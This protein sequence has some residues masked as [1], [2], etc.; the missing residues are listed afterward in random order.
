M[1]AHAMRTLGSV[2]VAAAL[3]LAPVRARAQSSDDGWSAFL[4]ALAAAGQ[5]VRYNTPEGDGPERAEGY[6]HV[7]RLVEFAEASF[8]DDADAAHPNVQ[9]CPS[10]ACKIGF[11]NPDQVYVGIGPISDAYTYRVFGQRGTVDFLSF[12]VFDNPY[13]GPAW[14]DSDALQVKADGSWE[15]VLSP[16]PRSGNWLPTTASSTQLV[17][18]MTFA[19]WDSE[20]EGSVQVEV[21]DDAARIPVPALVP[22]DFAARAR[23]L[24]TTLRA[25]PALFQQLRADLYPVNDFADPDPEAFGL[26]NAGLPTNVVSPAQYDLA[27][28]EALIVESA[29]VPVRFRNIQ[30]GN[31]W[32]E[33]LDY[34]TRQTSLNGAQSYLDRDGVYRFVLAHRDPGV[35][36]WLDVGG[37]PTGTIFMRWNRP[38]GLDAPKPTATVVKLAD[39]RAHLPADHPRVTADERAAMLERRRQAYDR[40]TNPAGLELGADRRVGSVPRL[41]VVRGAR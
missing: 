21:L 6:R 1:H 2:V 9:R 31:R 29:D 8:L 16:T 17:I 19:D 34:A 35:P 37:H 38:P 39:V 24:A 33:S 20:V 13:G 40:R 7:I 5:T 32:L 25:T 27:D 22:A 26:Q 41:P 14:M 18:R 12:Q 30:L 15:L 11:D 36:N 28:D 3:L 23:R 10:K 4:D